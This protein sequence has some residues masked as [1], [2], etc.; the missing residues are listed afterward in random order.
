MPQHCLCLA[1][2]LRFFDFTLSESFHVPSYHLHK[3]QSRLGRKGQ[4]CFGLELPEVNVGHALTIVLEHGVTIFGATDERAPVV[5]GF[6]PL[7][8]PCGV[9]VIVSVPSYAWQA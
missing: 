9:V 2:L 8:T 3:G 1:S 6:V 5:R 7:A 4:N